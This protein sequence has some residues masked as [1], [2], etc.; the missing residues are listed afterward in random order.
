MKIEEF[1]KL[2]HDLGIPIAYHHFICST[3]PPFL[4]Y[5]ASDTTNIY[6]DNIV[7]FTSVQCSL[8]L[9]FNKKQPELEESIE[10]ILKQNGIAF[11]KT[12]TYF[13][14]EKIYLILYEVELVH[15]NM[16]LTE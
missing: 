11:S 5:F 13:S 2:F 1:G 6:A 14:D 8:E 4:I 3:T 7:V 16:A 9:Y 12:E 10:Q 15:Q